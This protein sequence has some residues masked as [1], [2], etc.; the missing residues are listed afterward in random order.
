MTSLGRHLAVVVAGLL[1]F[2]LPSIAT[3]GPP[4]DDLK[5]YID[6]VV[7]I[8]EDP[9]MKG[10][11]H[12]TERQ[13]AIEAVA[14]EGLDLR[15]AARRTLAQYWDA[16]TPAEQTRF[17]ELFTA[18]IYGSY[19]VRVAHYN[20]ERVAFDGEAVSGNEAVVKA[21]VI[22]TDGD[23]TPVEFRLVR[24]GSERW[25]VWDASFEGM[26]LIGNYRA[27]FTRII[28]AGSFTDLVKRLES[29]PQPK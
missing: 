10:T 24:N 4:T 16:R 17:T 3:A 22:A 9:G 27:Q 21:R 12:A 20:G 5:G 26:S 29:H 8:L 18:L 23:I 2:A 19:L 25:K 14:N 15:E 6:R 13:H 7:A 11:T 1:L 28:R